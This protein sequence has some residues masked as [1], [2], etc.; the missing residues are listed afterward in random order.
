[1]KT[2]VLVSAL[3]TV[4]ML[5]GGTSSAIAK[6]F[7]GHDMG[8]KKPRVENRFDKH[9]ARSG[10]FDKRFVTHRSHRPGV[11]ARF[12]DRPIFGRFVTID[13]DRFWLADGVLYRVV[14]SGNS[15]IY[16]VVGYI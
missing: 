10:H 11:G 9:S 13:R 1:M 4:A 2:K 3:A 5:I 14:R 8:G 15:T 12:I 16:I 6:E 7:R